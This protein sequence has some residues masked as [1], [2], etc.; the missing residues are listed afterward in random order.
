MKNYLGFRKI[1][2]IINANIRSKYKF[3]RRLFATWGAPKNV[4]WGIGNRSCGFRIPSIEER[5]Y[6]LKIEFLDLI[7]IHI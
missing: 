2:S 4:K 3:F 6:V 7:Q 1:Y 5:I